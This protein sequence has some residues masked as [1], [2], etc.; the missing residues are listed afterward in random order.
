MTTELNAYFLGE[1]PFRCEECG[2]RFIQKEILK[3]HSMI[4][5][6]NTLFFVESSPNFFFLNFFVFQVKS[7]ISA[8]FVI[9]DSYKE[10]C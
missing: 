10:I 9:K 6:G 8:L 4:H 5:T 3:R 1:K 2:K 7:L